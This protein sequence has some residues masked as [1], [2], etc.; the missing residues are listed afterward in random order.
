MGHTMIGLVPRRFV[1]ACVL[2]TVL[3]GLTTR[4][5]G[6][7][8]VVAVLIAPTIVAVRVLLERARK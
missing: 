1:E 6:A 2:M 5:A 8:A 4:A 3:A 7:A